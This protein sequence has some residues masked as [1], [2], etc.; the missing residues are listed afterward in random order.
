MPPFSEIDQN[1]VVVHVGLLKA[2]FYVHSEI[3]RESAPFFEQAVRAKKAISLERVNPTTFRMFLL[4]LYMQTDAPQDQYV[5]PWMMES[6]KP[7]PDATNFPAPSEMKR[8]YKTDIFLQRQFSFVML[9]FLD[10]LI[11]AEQFS[12]PPLSRDVMTALLRHCARWDVLPD[13]SHRTLITRACEVLG[14]DSRFGDF[15]S[16]SCALSMV[17]KFGPN[18]E[19]LIPPEFPQSFIREL[20]RKY[21]QYSRGGH[22]TLSPILDFPLANRCFGHNHDD[23]EKPACEERITRERLLFENLIESS[24]YWYPRG[25]ERWAPSWTLVYPYAPHSQTSDVRGLKRETEVIDGDQGLSS[26]QC[27][28]TPNQRSSS[29]DGPLS[30]EWKLASDLLTKSEIDI[31]SE[32]NDNDHLYDLETRRGPDP[33]AALAAQTFEERP[34]PLI[35]LAKKDKERKAEMEAK[36]SCEAAREKV[37]KE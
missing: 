27:Q 10:L 17:L 16:T 6:I 25:R 5:D 26:G 22:R 37:A 14:S 15:L 11:F 36:Q 8:I 30:Q 21:Y 35:S 29:P 19:H 31:K 12:I 4:W 7:L 33:Q 20:Y 18:E 3:L 2:S 34:S 32:I 28:S 1:K 9:A 23:T 13:L 24:K